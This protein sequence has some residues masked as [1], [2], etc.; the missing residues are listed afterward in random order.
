MI[1]GISASGRDGLTAATVQAILA[2]AG[3]EYEYVSFAGKRINGCSGCTL[4][5]SDN[6]CKFQDD[7]N[8]ISDKMLQADAVIFGAPNHFRNMNALGRAFWERTFSFRHREAF[9]L[10]GKLGVIV[11]VEYE[12]YD[13]VKSQIEYFMLQNKMVIVESV[14]TSA[15]S[16]CYTCGFGHNCGAG[17]VVKTHGFLEKIEDKDFP[18]CFKE[19][20]QAQ[21]QAYKAGKMLGSILRNRVR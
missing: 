15:C 17:W 14:R 19:Q 18:P 11:S 3:L 12:G 5:A 8:E 6:I 9:N 16:P 4:C 2:A 10:A 13:M 20:Q 7:W 21:Y 1:L